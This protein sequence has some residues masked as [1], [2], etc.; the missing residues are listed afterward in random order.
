VNPASLIEVATSYKKAQIKNG[1]L[2]KHL[3][4]ESSLGRL[5]FK[6][7]CSIPK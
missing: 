3:E 1:L 4:A 7:C 2:V 5:E 6:S